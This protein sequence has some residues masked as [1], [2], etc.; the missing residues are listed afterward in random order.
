VDISTT[1]LSTTVARAFTVL[2]SGL[3]V[4]SRPSE[5]KM[6]DNFAV[7]EHMA[8]LQRVFLIRRVLEE[9]RLIAPK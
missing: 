1:D 7:R 9:H 6:R 8:N 5:I 2:A 4:E 3:A